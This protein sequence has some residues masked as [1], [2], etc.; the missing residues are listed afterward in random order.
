MASVKDIKSSCDSVSHELAVMKKKTHALRDDLQ[1]IY[2]EDS[3]Q[4]RT[5]VQ[6]LV[7]LADDI[8]RERYILTS[9]CDVEWEGMDGLGKNVE[10]IIEKR[11]AFLE[12]GKA[13]KIDLLHESFGP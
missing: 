10:E 2:G 3:E 12:R 13:L 9:G 5:N 8:E 6:H 1:M 7:E 11:V 4:F